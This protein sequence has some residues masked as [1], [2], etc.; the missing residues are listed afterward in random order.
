MKVEN[1]KGTHT[2]R[3]RFAQTHNS[4]EGSSHHPW[5]FSADKKG[6]K[7]N[8]LCFVWAP[9]LSQLRAR[10]GEETGAIGTPKQGTAVQQLLLSLMNP[11]PGLGCRGSARGA[12]SPSSYPW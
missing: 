3:G 11:S 5:G 1:T 2:P 4:R 8:D 12:L 9:A 7:H 10:S 6:F